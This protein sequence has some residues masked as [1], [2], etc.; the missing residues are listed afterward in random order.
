VG[1]YWNNL[2]WAPYLADTARLKTIPLPDPAIP[3]SPSP[4]TE[5][6]RRWIQRAS[7]YLGRADETPIAAGRSG[8]RFINATGITLLRKHGFP[9]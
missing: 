7:L 9:I 2:L 4:G 5:D 6:P 1:L 8:L 3:F